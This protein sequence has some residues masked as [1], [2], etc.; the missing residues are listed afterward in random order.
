MVAC[1]TTNLGGGVTLKVHGA[2]KVLAT[3]ALAMKMIQPFTGTSANS[4]GL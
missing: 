1:T 2:A 4:A 3:I